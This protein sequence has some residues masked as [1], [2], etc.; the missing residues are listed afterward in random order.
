MVRKFAGNRS[1][2]DYVMRP[3]GMFGSTLA[4][5][6][7]SAVATMVPTRTDLDGQLAKSARNFFY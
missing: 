5:A 4:L 1:R 7:A 6:R 2:A 3:L